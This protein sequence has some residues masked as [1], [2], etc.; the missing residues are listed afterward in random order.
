MA[1]PEATVA[2]L[3]SDVRL[4][5]SAA[6]SSSSPITFAWRKDQEPLRNAETENSAQVRGGGGGGPPGSPEGG[7]VEHTTVL[8]LRRVTFAQEGRYQCVI[9]NHFGSTYSNKARLVVNGGLWLPPATAG[10]FF[11]FFF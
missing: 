2:L 9:T 3:G 11:F 10:L 6:S 1:Q 7:V 5:C 8:H 4:S